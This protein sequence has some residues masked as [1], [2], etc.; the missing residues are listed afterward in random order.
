MWALHHADEGV[1]EES[2]YGEVP[3]P[4]MF[5]LADRALSVVYFPVPAEEAAASVANIDTAAPPEDI[6]TGEDSPAVM[7][8]DA[9]ETD[10]LGQIFDA[11]PFC[12]TCDNLSDI[13]RLIN[14][15]RNLTFLRKIHF[16]Q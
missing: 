7:V 9:A 10:A 16:G 12:Y 4:E 13:K 2:S 14:K 6:D 15:P 3:E 1:E 5:Y 8:T 11:N